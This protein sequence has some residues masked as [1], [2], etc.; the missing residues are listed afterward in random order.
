[1]RLPS[2]ELDLVDLRL[3][4]VP[5]EIA[6]ARDLNLRVEM[7]DVADDG[8]VLHR[9]HVVDGDDIDIAR[10]RAED[11]GARRR[12]FHR[13]HLIAFHRGLQRADRV[14]LGHEHAAAGVA[15]RSGRALADVAEAR[16]AGD[17]AR[18]HD[19]GR[20]ADAVDERLAAAVEIVELRLRHRVVDVDRRPQE[21][22]LLV[23]RIK[24]MHA[25]RRLFRDALDRQGVAPIPAGIGLEPLLD[26]G[27]ENFLF[28][29]RRLIEKGGVALLRAQA[30]DE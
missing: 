17:L 21:L 24:A 18:H 1:M 25:G 26:R 8:A 20:A 12:V 27:E 19:V 11:V 13:R 10:R 22:A 2:V 28:L 30:Q 4:I 16:D 15:Q 5:L 14:D 3:H 7:A 29:V 6:Q 9:A 23:H